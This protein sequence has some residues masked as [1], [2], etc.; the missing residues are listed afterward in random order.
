MQ[1]IRFREFVVINQARG[2]RH[3]N[4][5]CPSTQAPLPLVAGRAGPRT[6]AAT[7]GSKARAI[8]PL[9]RGLPAAG[10][11]ELFGGV[12]EARRL[13]RRAVGR[14]R[15]QASHGTC[16]SNVEQRRKEPG[17]GALGIQEPTLATFTLDGPGPR[18]QGGLSALR[19]RA[20]RIGR[21]RHSSDQP[22]QAKIP[23]RLRRGAR[24]AAHPLTMLVLQNF[25]V[26]D[27]EYGRNGRQSTLRRLGHR[28][29]TGPS[30]TRRIEA[31]LA[32]MRVPS[33]LPRR[34]L[35]TLPFSRG[36]N[37]PSEQSSR[38]P[39]VRKP[40]L[41]LPCRYQQRRVGASRA[42]HS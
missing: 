10:P 35:V 6:R 17:S 1:Q 34:A 3:H 26:P 15:N 13:R 27:S 41:R 18:L 21:S 9:D 38:Q 11:S 40:M 42:A 5:P 7:L 8:V 19:G 23:A 33:R 28:S 30:L 25:R 31:A 32:R 2:R 12:A 29:S 14:R 4:V 16:G 20:P 24:P 39:S 22:G 36:K 37:A